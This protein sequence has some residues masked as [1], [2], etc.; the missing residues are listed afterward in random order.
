MKLRIVP[1]GGGGGGW[2]GGGGSKKG[3]AHT[4]GDPLGVGRKGEQRVT[5]KKGASFPLS[6]S[7]PPPERVQWPSIH[8]RVTK[9]GKYVREHEA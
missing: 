1:R 3:S 4:V 5:K 8:M 7:C 9:G 6:L 2:W